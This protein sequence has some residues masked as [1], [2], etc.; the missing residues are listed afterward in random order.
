MSTMRRQQSKEHYLQEKVKKEP[1]D[2]RCKE[3]FAMLCDCSSLLLL[4]MF[5]F[6]FPFPVTFSSPKTGCAHKVP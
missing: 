1:E 5:P 4:V 3:V 6:A 2:N